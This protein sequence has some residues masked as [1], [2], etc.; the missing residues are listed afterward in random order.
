MKT[1]N[2]LRT[3]FVVRCRPKDYYDA[4]KRNN[5]DR[6][7]MQIPLFLGAIAIFYVSSAL[8]NGMPF[9]I[10]VIK[11]AMALRTAEQQQRQGR[12][13]EARWM[14]SGGN[15]LGS[16][17]NV[18]QSQDQSSERRQRAGRQNRGGAPHARVEQYLGHD[19]VPAPGGNRSGLSEEV[20]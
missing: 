10:I 14:S 19:S 4:A 17:Q 11:L 6:K 15:L 9:D 18:G 5:K 13:T 12:L 16:D 7:I 1:A 3:A 20:A 2:Q 8:N